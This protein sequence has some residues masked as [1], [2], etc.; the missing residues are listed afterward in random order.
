MA[1]GCRT[2]EAD[3]VGK[4]RGR[5]HQAGTGS[6][7]PVGCQS[8]R[9]AALLRLSP[10]SGCRS[11]GRKLKITKPALRQRKRA[12]RVY[13][14]APRWADFVFFVSRPARHFESEHASPASSANV[15]TASHS[16][17]DLFLIVDHV[18]LASHAA[19][20]PPAPLP[21]YTPSSC[22]TSLP[23]FSARVRTS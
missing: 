22:H 11:A 23:C 16:E 2:G 17:C 9:R 14:G 7:M 8:S 6:R 18:D 15:G 12:C 13:I 1:E 5:C 19:L 10:P 20:P 4:R 21:P 3:I